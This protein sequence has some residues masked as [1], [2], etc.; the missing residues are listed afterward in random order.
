MYECMHLFLCMCMYVY[1]LSICCIL[2]CD[3]ES[4]ESVEYVE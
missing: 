3:G 1:V 4:V 2:L